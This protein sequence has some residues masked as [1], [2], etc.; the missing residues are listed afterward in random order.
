MHERWLQFPPVGTIKQNKTKQT[1]NAMQ[2]GR[3]F[4]LEIVHRN[5]M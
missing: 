5:A 4:S 1:V 2:N 3:L